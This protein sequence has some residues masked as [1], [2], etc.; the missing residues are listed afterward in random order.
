[1]VAAH[2]AVTSVDRIVIE[3]VSEVIPA[4]PGQ[5]FPGAVRV[6]SEGAAVEAVG[7]GVSWDGDRNERQYQSCELILAFSMQEKFNMC[8]TSSRFVFSS[9]ANSKT[10][11][12]IKLVLA[13]FMVFMALELMATPLSNQTDF[14]SPKAAVEALM[15]ALEHD[16]VKALLKIFDPKYKQELTGGDTAA[17]RHERQQVLTAMQETWKLRNDGKDRKVLIIGPN[18]WP[19]PFPL[20]KNGNRWRFDTASGIEEV[21]E[22]HIG[23]NELNA[24]EMC[25]EYLDAQLKYARKDRDGDGV[26]E[27]AQQITRSPGQKNG[28][29]W[30]SK[31]GQDVSPF[32]PLVA[33]ARGYLQGR[34][35][36]DPYKGYY[37]KILT[38]QGALQ[39]G[40][41]YDYII[42][43]NMIAGFGL[44]SYPAEYGN[45]G[46][47]SF[48]CNHQGKV[49]Q[50]DLGQ[51]TELIARGIDV[52]NPNEIWELVKKENDKQSE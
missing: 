38:R 46:I 6:A 28:L 50:A 17:S 1:M 49:F 19:F 4:D 33:D 41:R 29:Y 44:I 42:N 45:S 32:G 35:P 3:I 18:A 12:S 25:S 48:V 8:I 30:S 40:G 23:E 5:V 7:G 34:K 26:L 52:Y 37:F 2:L 13:G 31:D 20:V 15:V 39:P 43:G 14:E 36:A 27:Y 22:R 9:Q 51:N 21:I 16:N 24:I 47:M 10:M 11:F